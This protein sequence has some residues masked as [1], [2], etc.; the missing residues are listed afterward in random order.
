M[1]IGIIMRRAPRMSQVENTSTRRRRL[2][3][4]SNGLLA[5]D[6]KIYTAQ[7]V[8]TLLCLT[9][10]VGQF[11]KL[12]TYLKSTTVPFCVPNFIGMGS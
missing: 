6:K 3:V 9:L 10:S 5:V 7:P 2:F 8:K 11:Q 12:K 1:A 4:P